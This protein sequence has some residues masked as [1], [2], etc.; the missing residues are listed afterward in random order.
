MVS[1]RAKLELKLNYL[2]IRAEETRRIFLDEISVLIIE[3]TGC[4]VTVSLLE[5]L[6]KRRIAI[7]FCDGKR[8]PGA[9][10]LQLYGSYDTSTKILIQTNWSQEAKDNVWKEIIREKIINQSACLKRVDSAVSE[11]VYSYA[12]EVLPGDESNREG[13]AA[14]VYF[15]SLFNDSFSRSEPCFINSCLDYGYAILLSAVARTVVANG[16]ITQLGIFHRNTFNEFNL[17]CDLMEPFR[18]IVDHC[19]LEFPDDEYEIS[20]EQKLL[21]A[22]ILTSNVY[23]DK[24]RHTVLD[25]VSIYVRSVLEALEAN[26]VSL[27]KFYRYEF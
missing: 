5:A 19:V 22:S 2:V 9:Q 12:S 17:A 25:A 16:Y 27:I 7:I 1:S 26:D 11:Q 8:L 6:W 20:L 3:N 13:H 14:K 21:L 18:P 10:L 15:N 4:A 24:A 23:I